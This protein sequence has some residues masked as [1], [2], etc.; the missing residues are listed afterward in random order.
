MLTVVADQNCCHCAGSIHQGFDANDMKPL[1]RAY[2]D[3]L[4]FDD[5]EDAG[6]QHCHG[7]G[8]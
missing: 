5:P 2:K 1:F 7:A 8:I 4:I 6:E 3:I